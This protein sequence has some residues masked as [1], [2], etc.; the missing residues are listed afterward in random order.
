MPRDTARRVIL[1]SP[2]ITALHLCLYFSQQS[3]GHLALTGQQVN[4]K[5]AH[6]QIILR[7]EHRVRRHFLQV[8]IGGAEQRFLPDNRILCFQQELPHTA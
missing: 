1:P 5:G 2:R 6:P 8:N 4:S 3:G 7:I